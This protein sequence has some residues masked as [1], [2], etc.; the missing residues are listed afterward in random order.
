M[1]LVVV[2][3][4]R[5]WLSSARALG[6]PLW[7]LPRGEISRISSDLALLR[8][9]VGSLQAESAAVKLENLRPDIVLHVGYAGALRA[10]LNAGDLLTVTASSATL[11]DPDDQACQIPAARPTDPHLSGTLRSA[12][13]LLPGRMAQGGLL[14]VTRFIDR[15]EDKVR[16][17]SDGAYVACDMEATAICSAAARCGARYVGLRAIS[18]AS[19]H[20]MP[21]GVRDRGLRAV[22]AWASNP[23][24]ASLDSWHMVH[25]WS[26]AS[27]SIERAL[28]SI[29]RLL[30]DA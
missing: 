10:G 11:C 4:S 5:E 16:L 28:P 27:A 19:H 8:T 22:L 3:S 2:A 9:G 25:G 1:I 15:S 23:A 14:T 29:V 18:D 30:K 20:Q 21:P 7:H 13:A 6:L 26:R 24:R 12:L 17:G